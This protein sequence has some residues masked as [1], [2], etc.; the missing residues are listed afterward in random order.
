M[1]N[2]DFMNALGYL[3]Q[4]ANSRVA[5]INLVTDSFTQGYQQKEN[6]DLIFSSVW[7]AM[8]PDQ[9]SAFIVA[10]LGENSPFLCLGNETLG[11]IASECLWKEIRR[12]N[13]ELTVLTVFQQGLVVAQKNCRY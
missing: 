5:L 10:S 3:W 13:L 7:A 8:I 12:R 2:N 6:Q 4:E 9:F 11:E 1:A